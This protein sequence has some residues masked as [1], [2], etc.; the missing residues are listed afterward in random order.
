MGVSRSSAAVAL[1][2]ARVRPDLPAAQIL[3]EVLCIRQR[4]WPNLRLIELGDT[5]LERDG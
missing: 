3:N 1:I 4:A 2:L 5:A